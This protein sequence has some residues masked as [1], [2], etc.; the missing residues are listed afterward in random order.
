MTPAAE[1]TKCVLYVS[2]LPPPAGGISNW[3][4]ILFERG[5]PFGWKCRIVDTAV[6]P[7]RRVF[8][9]G[10]LLPEL[11]RAFRVISRFVIELAVHRPDVVH[12]N[13][14]PLTPG[15]FRDAICLDIARL[16][17]IPTIL[18]HHCLVADSRNGPPRGVLRRVVRHAA[19][20]ASVNLVLNDESLRTLQKLGGERVRVRKMPNWYDETEMPD[21]ATPRREGGQPMRVG[22]AGG[23]TRAKGVEHLVELARRLPEVEFHLVGSRYEETDAILKNAPASLVVHGEVDHGRALDILAR[24]HV[25]VFPTSF[26]EGFPN[27]VC[28]AMAL[29]LAVVATPVGAIP[30]MIP[31]GQGGFIEPLDLDA[32]EAALRE[33]QRDEPRRFAQGSFNRERA[34]QLYTFPEVSRQIAEVYEVVSRSSAV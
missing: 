8:E 14:N 17:R 28:E 10:R 26:P 11:L 24:C 34:K 30:E 13:V 22:F 18:H 12:V 27:V 32:F 21:I 9:R 19:R 33:L 16:L 31:S 23:L 4:R 5:L 7:H 25:L 2:P 15:L 1:R 3:T 29:G 6:S 20:A